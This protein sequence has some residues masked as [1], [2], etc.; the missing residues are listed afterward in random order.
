MPSMTIRTRILAAFL[1]LLLIPT[2]ILVLYNTWQILSL[3]EENAND[4]AS[5]LL[6]V[7]LDHLEGLASDEAQRVNE[8]FKQID[9]EITM[10]DLYSEGLFNGIVNVT[11]YQ[12]YWWN[13]SAEFAQTGRVIPG[14]HYDPGYDSPDI[15]FDVS[16]LF[17][18]MVSPF[19]LHCKQSL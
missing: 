19:V 10:L 18:V 14:R 8:I 11:P 12:S 13:A 7:E 9:A 15:S 4:A 6:Q 1:L 3:S 17:A 16:C 2:S 5:A